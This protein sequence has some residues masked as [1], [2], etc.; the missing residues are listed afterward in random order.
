MNKRWY[1]LALSMSVVGCGGSVDNGQPAATGGAPQYHYGPA[2][3]DAGKP[4]ETGGMTTIYYGVAQYTGGASAGGS[5]TGVA[6]ST[7]ANPMTTGGSTSIDAGTPATG[8]YP[9]I[10]M[11]MANLRLP[12]QDDDSRQAKK[13][14]ALPF[15]PRVAGR[16]NSMG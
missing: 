16:A 6:T 13:Y 10:P 2:F 15:E 1:P 5:D 3:I 11:Y 4:L 7:Q 14:F 12:S 8:G 9:A